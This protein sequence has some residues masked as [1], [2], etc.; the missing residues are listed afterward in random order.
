V[1]RPVA[2][3]VALVLAVATDLVAAGCVSLPRSGPVR[4]EAVSNQSESDALVD[5]TPPGPRRGTAPVP[6]VDNF[7][8]AMT[9]TPLNTYV[10][11]EYLTTSSSRSWAPEHGTIVYGNQQILPRP[12]GV[13]VRLSD[14]VALDSRGEWR[15]DPTHGRGLS[16]HLRLV[17]EDGQWRIDQPPDRLLIPRA[18]FD[19]QYEQYLLYFFDRTAQVLVPEPVY[20]PRGS[21]ASTLLVAGLLQGPEPYLRGTERSFFPD[22]S[23]LDGISV[24]VSRSGTAEVPLN[25]QVLD[26]GD[27]QLGKLFAQLAWT[28]AQVS[29]VERVR[30]TVDGTP[31]DLP[32]AGADVAV[33]SWSGYDPSVAWASTALFGI[34][35]GH[36]VSVDGHGEDRISGVLG[37]RDVGLRSIAVDLLGQH[38]AGVS[39]DGRRVWQTDRDGVPGRTATRADLRTVYSGSDVLQPAYDLYGQLWLVDRTAGG[40]RLSVVHAGEARSVTAA[41]LSGTDLTRFALSRDGTRLLAEVRRAGQDRLLLVR[42]RRDEK[43]RVLGLS[44]PRRLLVPGLSSHIRDIAWRTPASAVVLVDG[45]QGTSQVVGVKIDGPADTSA[46]STAETLR[47]RGMRL[48]AAPGAPLYVSTDSGRLYSLTRRGWVASPIDPG[49]GAPTFVG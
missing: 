44:A 21:Q 32:N 2:L 36:V 37:T 34:R 14:V 9:A 45:Q 24:P 41:G 29:G 42:V 28:L 48:V 22:G 11:R 18:Q 17:K 27:K 47:G 19:S 26:V 16:I 1:R 13:V 12:G 4:T 33:D 39:A 40:A 49:L 38:V 46:A 43:G 31:V 8:L 35:D 15:G 3:V 23:S 20:V 7:L 6:L 5:Y 10:A 30:V 25:H